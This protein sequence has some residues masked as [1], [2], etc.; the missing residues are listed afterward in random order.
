MH[1]RGSSDTPDVGFEHG[2]LDPMSTVFSMG[3]Q[4]S[5]TGYL[6]AVFARNV[7]AC[8][9]RH[10]TYLGHSSPSM[11]GRPIFDHAADDFDVVRRLLERKRRARS[12]A[13]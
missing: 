1:H 4:R 8:V 3:S 9:S 7:E 13:R 6:S 10:E 12:F 11:F 2:G 5:G